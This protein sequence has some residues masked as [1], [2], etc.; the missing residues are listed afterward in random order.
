MIV[1]NTLNSHF[2]TPFLKHIS[3]HCKPN[4]FQYSLLPGVDEKTAYSAVKVMS[5]EKEIRNYWYSLGSAHEIKLQ[6]FIICL[7]KK[8]TDIAADKSNGDRLM[9]N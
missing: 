8:R 3:W 4:W 6:Q 9:I 7:A 1:V 5:L 2:E